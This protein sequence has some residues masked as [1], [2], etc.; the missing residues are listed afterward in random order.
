MTK[1]EWR[2]FQTSLSSLVSSREYSLIQEEIEFLNLKLKELLGDKSLTKRMLSE[3]K[4]HRGE[5]W[6]ILGKETKNLI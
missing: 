4:N 6:E 5:Y 1:T 3:L 2:S